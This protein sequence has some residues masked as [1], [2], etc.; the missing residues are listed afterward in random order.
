MLQK[1]LVACAFFL[2]AAAGEC[3]MEIEDITNNITSNKLSCSK[4]NNE[5]DLPSTTQSSTREQSSKII[6]NREEFLNIDEDEMRNIQE[7]RFEG[8][9]LDKAVSQ[10]FGVMGEFSVIEFDGCK[11]LDGIRFCEILDSCDV[12][13]LSI[14]NCP[15]DAH[16]LQEVLL[17]VNPYLIDRICISDKNSSI[18]KEEIVENLKGSPLSVCANINDILIINEEKRENATFGYQ[19]E[20]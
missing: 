6:K 14:K 15:I 18:N 20:I 19:V 8:I 10:K 4:V 7:L 17:R 1:A 3:S 13:E 9:E 5:V 16:D 12:K 11:L 2:S